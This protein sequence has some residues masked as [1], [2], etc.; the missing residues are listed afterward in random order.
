MAHQ[1]ATAPTLRITG[2]YI[3]DIVEA[4]NAEVVLFADDAAFIISAPTLQ[5]MYDKITQLFLDVNGYL[6]LNKLVPNLNK[7]KLMYFSSKPKVDLQELMFAGEVIEWVEEFKYLGLSLTNKMSYSC[8]IENISTKISR[9]IGIFYNLNKILPREVLL[10]LYHSFV[11]PHL[12]LHI[13]LW[14]LPPIY[15]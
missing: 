7:S 14:G 2:L 6:V 12:T 13:V 10:L 3:N 9:Y 15:I 11:L 1:G 8:H 4:V 5:E